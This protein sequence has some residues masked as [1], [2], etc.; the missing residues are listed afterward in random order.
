MTAS[1]ICGSVTVS[2][3]RKPDFIHDCDCGLCRKAGAAWGY[4]AASEI[5]TSGRTTSFVR[6]DKEGAAA[7]VH[8][9][10]I[11]GATT[12][13]DLTDDFKANNPSADQ[14][15]VNMRLFGRFDLE[16]VEVRYP[17]G[18]NWDGKGAFGYRRGPMV[19]GEES[20]L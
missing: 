8:S 3:V 10:E 19:I 14:V 16:G 2:V 5:T 13:F 15:G 17:D 6:R 9:C 1:C 7:Q 20:P 18:M 12:H 4:F 11:C